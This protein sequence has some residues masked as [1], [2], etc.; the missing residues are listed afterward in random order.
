[1]FHL[2]FNLTLFSFL[3]LKGRYKQKFRFTNRGRRSQQIYWMTEGFAPSKLRR[4]RQHNPQDVMFKVL[5]TLF[6]FDSSIKKLLLR[7][8]PNFIYLFFLSW[9]LGY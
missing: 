4:K 5:L 9:L 8:Q 3:L 7:L 2:Q 6:I 1:M